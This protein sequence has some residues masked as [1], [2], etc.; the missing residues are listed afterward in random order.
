MIAAAALGL[1]GPDLT[2]EV[3][4]AAFIEHMQSGFGALNAVQHSVRLSTTPA[5]WSPPAMRSAVIRHE[6]D[7]KLTSRKLLTPTR[8]VLRFLGCL[9]SEFGTISATDEAII[10][11]DRRRHDGPHGS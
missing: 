9:K 10:C 8:G 7:M 3:V 1:N 6:A 4:H 2:G 11:R 5:Q